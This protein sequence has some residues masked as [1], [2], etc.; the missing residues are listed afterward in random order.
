MKGRPKKPT[1]IKIAEGNRGK[2][3]L[4]PT[5]EPQ[6]STSLPV[7]PDFLDKDARA[8][9]DSMISLMDGLGLL[10]AADGRALAGY[11]Q[12]YSLW[13]KACREFEKEE[14]KVTYLEFKTGKHYASPLV[15][16]I[17]SLTNRMFS[18]LSH[19]GMTPSS[20]SKVSVAKQDKDPFDEFQKQR[21]EM[22]GQLRKITGTNQEA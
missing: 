17:D 3:P 21:E 20:R 11:C 10:T 2:R 12:T 18:Y 9:W 13:S 1:Q 22:R 14:G 4:D 16:V 7:A 6:F 8:E 5:T 15:G 19:F